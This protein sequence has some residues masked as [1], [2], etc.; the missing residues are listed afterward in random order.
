MITKFSFVL[1]IVSVILN[2]FFL[3]ELFKYE[4]NLNSF[5]IYSYRHSDLRSKKELSIDFQH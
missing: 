3:S 5:E 1:V 2:I 4:Q